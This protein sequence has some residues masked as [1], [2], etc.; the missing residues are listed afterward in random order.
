MTGTEDHFTYTAAEST[1][2]L[3][4]TGPVRV[5]VRQPRGR[6]APREEFH[7]TLARQRRELEALY[8]HRRVV[9]P[10]DAGPRDARADLQ[11]IAATVVVARVMRH[12]QRVAVD[13]E[14]QRRAGRALED[15]RDH[16][17]A[18]QRFS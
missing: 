12:L 6:S 10:L 18:A 7:A 9:R 15:A 11:I 5:Q 17:F 4:G 8:E 1:I 14:G 3:Y 16:A 13:L 2:V